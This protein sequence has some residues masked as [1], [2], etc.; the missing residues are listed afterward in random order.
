MSKQLKPS[1]LFT[2][3]A[4]LCRGKEIRLFGEAPE[5]VRVSAALADAAGKVLAAGA[6]P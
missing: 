1:A 2:D 5:G 6:L 3:G 4:V